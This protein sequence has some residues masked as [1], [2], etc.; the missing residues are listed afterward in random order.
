MH[1]GAAALAIVLLVAALPAEAQPVGKALTLGILSPQPTPTPEQRGRGVFPQ[2]LRELGWIPGKNLII[3]RAYGEGREDL[4]PQLAEKLVQQRVDVIFAVGPPSALAA[5]RATTTIPIVFWGVSFPVELG[6]VSSLARPGGNVTGVAFSPGLELIGK[7]LEFLKQIA[8]A[9]K[10]LAWITGP[11]A[12]R[13]TGHQN[14][15]ETATRDLGFELGL[16]VVHRVEDFDT[17]FA[18][19]TASRTQAIALIGNPLTARERKRI[20]EFANRNRLA[21]AFGMKQFVRRGV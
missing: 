20:V 19:M 21:S 2:K 3:Q 9:A 12:V 8:P 13:T 7:Q 5:A 17:V 14:A 16:H 15:V 18:S 1:L 4:L 10:R 11:Q 6:L